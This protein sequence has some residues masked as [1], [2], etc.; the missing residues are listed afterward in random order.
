M[1]GNP[2]HHLFDLRENR[3]NGQSW[4]FDKNDRKPQG[5]GRLQLC[6]GS[7]TTRV[8]GNDMGDTV[9]LQKRQI[10]RHR[11]GP[12]VDDGAGV[13]QG[14]C[15]FGRVDKSQK[16]MVLRLSGEAGKMQ[17]ANRQ[18]DPRRGVGQGVDGRIHACDL[19]PV[20]AGTG[21]PGR[22][23]KGA[24]PGAG[25][26][27]GLYRVA[28]HLCRERMGGINQMRHPFGANV[29]GQPFGPAKAADSGGQGLR[30][31]LFGATRI[32]KDRSDAGLRHGAGQVRGFGGSAED[33][34]ARHGS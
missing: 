16:I 10:I 22:A 18:K 29:I 24:E 5:A 1:S 3:S 12:A 26:R 15:T 32:G 4:P 31:R 34:E 21:N 2:T 14:Q 20:V 9:G 30:Q 17:L 11:K 6:F 19:L 23:F 28:T 27:A 25:L 8:L 13:R 33:K 7:C